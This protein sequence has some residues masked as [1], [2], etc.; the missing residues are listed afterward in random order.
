MTF[1]EIK[2][3]ITADH[4]ASLPTVSSISATAIYK[5]W[6]NIAANAIWVMHQIFQKDQ[7]ALIELTERR[8]YGT[9]GWYASEAL[10]FQLGDALT[11]NSTTGQFYY[12]TVNL[13]ARIIKRSAVIE[14]NLTGSLTMKVAKLSGLNLIPLTPVEQLAFINYI[15]DIKVA[16]TNIDVISLP[17]DTINIVAEVFYDANILQ[18][19]LEIAIQAKLDEYRV[20]TEFNGIVLKNKLIDIIRELIG[21]DDV[22][23]TTITGN[24]AGSPAVTIIREYNTTSG[25]FEFATNMLNSWTFTPRFV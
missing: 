12:P 14:N 16:G 4:N 18:P 6:I 2:D 17:A 3:Q 21:V 5:I 15:Q 23:F 11:F 24:Y 10:L 19:N 1:Q 13:P 22:L 20:N 8:R 9:V 7:A 25:Y